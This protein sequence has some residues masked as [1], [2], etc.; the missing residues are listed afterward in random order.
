MQK[1]IV[2]RIY[3]PRASFR[4]GYDCRRR[5]FAGAFSSIYEIPPNIKNK[6]V[7]ASDAVSLVTR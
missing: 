5:M 4:L 7:T 1:E 6:V 2:R 3:Q